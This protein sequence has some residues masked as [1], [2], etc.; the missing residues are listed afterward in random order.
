MKK[1]NTIYVNVKTGQVVGP[2][3]PN[4][5][6]YVLLETLN[7]TERLL[8]ANREQL[9]SMKQDLDTLIERNRQLANLLPH[10]T[11]PDE[12]NPLHKN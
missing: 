11:F 5:V 12:Q 3:Y 2:N 7:E 6:A 4:A 1:E 8:D 10:S 9:R